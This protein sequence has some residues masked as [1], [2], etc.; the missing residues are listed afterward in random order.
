M[1]QFILKRSNL[2][3]GFNLLPEEVTHVV[4]IGVKLVA[5]HDLLCLVISGELFVRHFNEGML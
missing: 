4:V 2:F 1:G 5:S 3:S